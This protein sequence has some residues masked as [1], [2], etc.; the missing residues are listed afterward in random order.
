MPRACYRHAISNLQIKNLPEGLHAELRRR[1]GRSG[2]TVRDYVL[3]LIEA[4]QRL[5]STEDWLDE[6]RAHP[7]VTISADDVVRAI[8]EARD[9]R[10]A[11]VIDAATG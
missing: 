11:G 8:E 9:G 2:L 1:A 6:L 5:P 3:R 10:D 7:P 4:D